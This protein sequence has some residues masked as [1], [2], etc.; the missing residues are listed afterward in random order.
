[1]SRPMTRGTAKQSGA[2]CLSS[3]DDLHICRGLHLADLPPTQEIVAYCRGN[4]SML[5]SE[6]V[7]ALRARS[8]RVRRLEQGFQ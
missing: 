5:S 4:F 2:G 8:Q 1:M 6:A 3:P 7:A